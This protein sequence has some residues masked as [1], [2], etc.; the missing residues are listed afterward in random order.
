MAAQAVGDAG[1]RSQ[2]PEGHAWEIVYV[3]VRATSME[4]GAWIIVDGDP[5][6]ARHDLT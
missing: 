4:R 2:E 3:V 1:K 5:L 6:H